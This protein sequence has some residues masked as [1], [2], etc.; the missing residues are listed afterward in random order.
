MANNKT[1]ASTQQ[2]LDIDDITEDLVLAKSD[3]VA[4]IM[5]TTAVNFDILSEAEQD[6]TIYAYGR[7]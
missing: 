1:K 6:A 4:L 2:H 3:Q 5:I 7:F